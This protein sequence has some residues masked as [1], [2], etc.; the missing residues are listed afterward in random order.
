MRVTTKSWCLLALCL[1]AI[2]PL[3]MGELE[4]KTTFMPDDCPEKA[5]KGVQVRGQP[6]SHFSRVSDHVATSQSACND[7]ACTMNC[8]SAHC[9]L[10]SS[11]RA[12]V[13]AA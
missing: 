12:A 5:K 11:P 9:D 13:R 1:L 10:Y 6:R 7:E 3:V 2:W 4:I 8:I